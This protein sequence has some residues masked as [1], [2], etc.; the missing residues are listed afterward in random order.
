MSIESVHL[1]F[2]SSITETERQGR[3]GQ[4]LDKPTNS[5]YR[6]KWQR[7]V[8]IVVVTRE[9]SHG[10]KILKTEAKIFPF[11]RG[12]ISGAAWLEGLPI[13]KSVMKHFVY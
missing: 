5:V 9:M 11:F 4:L 12:E 8:V 10:H 13:D 6:A 3:G 7:L 2:T 1:A